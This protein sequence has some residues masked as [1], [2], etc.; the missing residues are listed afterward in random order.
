MQDFGTGRKVG[1]TQK[2][3]GVAITKIGA[4]T[5]RLL[6]RLTATLDSPTG[7]VV[8]LQPKSP[9]AAIITTKAASFQTH[10][11]AKLATL[12]GI[13]AGRLPRSTGVARTR[14]A[15]VR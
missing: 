1:V 8:G 6:C 4:A 9:I 2:N 13:L 10:M 5:K 7:N 11:T 15:A 3:I 14:T 12:I